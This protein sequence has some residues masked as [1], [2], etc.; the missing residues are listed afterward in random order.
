MP[1]CFR[2]PRI[3]RDSSGDTEGSDRGEEGEEFDDHN[4]DD[5]DMMDETVAAMV[6]TSLSVS[7][8]SPPFNTQYRGELKLKLFIIY[9]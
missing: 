8:K 2:F 4:H 9:I 1:I 3:H 7:P 5:I 6:L